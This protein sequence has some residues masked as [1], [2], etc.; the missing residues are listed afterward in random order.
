[1]KTDA[2]W[3]P[4]EVGMLLADRRMNTITREPDKMSAKPKS[5][6]AAVANGNLA[7]ASSLLGSGADPNA[8]ENEWSRWLPLHEGRA[9]EWNREVP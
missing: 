4:S 5:L 2:I 1:M 3:T 9:H 8:Q 7:E 6:H